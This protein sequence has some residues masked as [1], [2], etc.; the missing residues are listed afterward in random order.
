ML[1]GSKKLDSIRLC[2]PPLT[3]TAFCFHFFFFLENQFLK[4]PKSLGSVTEAFF[5]HTSHL[6]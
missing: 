2:I 5:P 6:P 1:Q 4:W 3:A